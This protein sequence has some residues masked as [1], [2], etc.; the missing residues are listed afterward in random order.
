[1]STCAA[2]FAA[3]VLGGLGATPALAAAGADTTETVSQTQ[4]T[5]QDCVDQVS[6]AIDA[7]TTNLT[8]D[9][10][11]H[12]I[13]LDTSAAQ[14]VTLADVKAAKPYLSSTDYQSLVVAAAAG[15]V[16]GK[17]FSQFQNNITDS[18]TQDGTFYYDGSHAWVTHTYRG[19]NGYH[20]CQV[21]YEVGYDVTNVACTDS[22]SPSQR[23]LTMTWKFSPLGVGSWS[24]THKMYVN[25]AGSMW[26]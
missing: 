12:T 2:A 8:L 20:T 25:A 23:T 15:S 11:T 3:A 19:Y 5:N 16:H 13:T 18:E 21:D 9:A 4:V 10:C 1:M 24:E 7:G 26:Q 6:A 14:P 22:G 17:H